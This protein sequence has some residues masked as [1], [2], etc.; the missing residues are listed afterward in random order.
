MNE[1]RSVKRI[2]ALIGS[3]SSS[4]NYFLKTNHK[5]AFNHAAVLLLIYL[6]NE[7]PSVSYRYLWVQTTKNEVF[8][9]IST[10]NKRKGKK[11]KQ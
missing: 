5:S 2:E 7:M 1:S 3:G 6:G 11:K 4:G 8:K 10:V 9:K